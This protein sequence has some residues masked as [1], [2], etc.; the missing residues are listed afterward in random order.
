MASLFK[1]FSLFPLWVAHLAGW[2]FGWLAYGLSGSY[3]QSFKDNVRQAGV[4]RR[5]ARRAVGA[6][7]Q[8]ISELPRLWFGRDVKVQWTGE[9]LIDA[10]LATE[11]GIVFLTPHLGCFEIT[12]QAYAQRF[13]VGVVAE[14][15]INQAVTPAESATEKGHRGRPMTVLFR[16]PRKAWLTDLVTQARKRPGLDTAPTQLS[17]VKQLIKALKKGNAVGVLPDQVPPAGQGIWSP[18]FGRSAYTMTLAV[19]LALQ[20]QSTILI[21]W[22]ER[23]SWGRG[24]VIHVSLLQS[25]STGQAASDR[26]G[27]SDQGGSST[28]G[29]ISDASDRRAKARDATFDRRILA[30]D[31]EGAVQQVN[32]AMENVIRTCPQQYLWGYARYKQPKLED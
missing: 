20:T 23:L 5:A 24:Y 8:Q 4:S 29:S 26:G 12:A 15:A 30:R 2:V 10:A 21:A 28:Y 1:F 31:L 18:F 16:P 7:G 9:H 27:Q 14:P 19:R 13:G 17:G 22:G 32:I 3:R 11:R 6:A 25:Y